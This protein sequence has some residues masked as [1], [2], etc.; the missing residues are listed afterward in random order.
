MRQSGGLRGGMVILSRL[1][2]SEKYV[3]SM[4]KVWVDDL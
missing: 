2:A 1:A 3:H 4:H